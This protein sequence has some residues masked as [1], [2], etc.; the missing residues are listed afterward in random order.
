M[1][2]ITI[3]KEGNNFYSPIAYGK[4]CYI[5]EEQNLEDFFDQQ[6]HDIIDKIYPIGAYYISTDSISPKEHFNYGTWEL[7]ES[8]KTILG[9]GSAY[10]ISTWET[11]ELVDGSKWAKIYYQDAITPWTQ[12]EETT[13][14]YD[15]LDQLSKFYNEDGNLELMMEHPGLELNGRWI[16]SAYPLSWTASAND[17][18]WDGVVNRANYTATNVNE[19]CYLPESMSAANYFLGLGISNSTYSK[20]SGCPGY[21]SFR[22][23]LRATAYDTATTGTNYLYCGTAGYETISRTLWVRYDNVLAWG[24]EAGKTGGAESIILTTGQIPP[25]RHGV[26]RTSVRRTGSYDDHGRGSTPGGSYT[27]PTGNN[28]AHNNLQPYTNVFIWQRI[29]GEEE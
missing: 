13:L 25:H 16:Q 5:S 21:G 23:G 24:I 7:L 14:I 18:S 6:F 9:A 19:G 20:I 26:G 10:D 29:R 27:T 2:K 1:N 15:R 8:G 28:S 17:T 22:F 11:K 4:F 12:V 3:S